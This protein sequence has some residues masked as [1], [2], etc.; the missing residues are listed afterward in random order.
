VRHFCTLACCSCTHPTVSVAQ[1][2]VNHVAVTLEAS[3][4]SGTNAAGTAAT[5]SV[6][7]RMS[8]N[9]HIDVPPDYLIEVD[10][11]ILDDIRLF[12][13]DDDGTSSPTREA[14]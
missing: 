9:D 3:S 7:A 4:S 14:L 8:A 6:A 10:E 11:H 2:S 5:S 13:M 1:D 12:R